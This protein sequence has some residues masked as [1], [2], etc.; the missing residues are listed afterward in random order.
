[1]S[2]AIERA[3]Q[4]SPGDDGIEVVSVQTAWIE[5]RLKCQLRTAEHVLRFMC[6]WD[7]SLPAK[8][9]QDFGTAFREMLLNAMEHGGHMNPELTVDVTCLRTSRM[10]LYEIRDPGQGFSMDSLRHAAVSN[11]TDAPA[12]HVLYR[13]EQDMRA[14]GFGILISRSLV[15]ELI[16]NEKGNEVV[17]IKYLG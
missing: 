16:Y 12:A 3:L 17:L 14:G 2:E 9:S 1:V 11:P 5:L 8:E 10:L 13:S 6:D 15:D 7:T 4:E